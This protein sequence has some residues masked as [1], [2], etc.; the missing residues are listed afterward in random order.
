MSALSKL[1]LALYQ[2]REREKKNYQVLVWRSSTTGG[3]RLATDDNEL[4][5]HTTSDKVYSNHVTPR[6]CQMGRKGLFTVEKTEAESK[7]EASFLSA[8]KIKCN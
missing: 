6:S 8:R 1:D 3:E 2:E 7:R 4:S 5:V